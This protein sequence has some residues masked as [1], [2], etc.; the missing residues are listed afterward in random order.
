MYRPG[1]VDRSACVD[2]S[3]TVWFWFEFAGRPLLPV[4]HRSSALDHRLRIY[5]ECAS[6][7]VTWTSAIFA[8]LLRGPR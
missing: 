6:T 1:K 2:T 8:H 7:S 3:F 4:H 5:G